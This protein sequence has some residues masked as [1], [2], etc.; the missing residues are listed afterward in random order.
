MG[1]D[2]SIRFSK[3]VVL[4]LIITHNHLPSGFTNT[5]VYDTISLLHLVN[6]FG[7]L[8]QSGYYKRDTYQSDQRLLVV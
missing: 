3:G 6:N 2:T 4:P 8:F 5:V 1:D 7:L